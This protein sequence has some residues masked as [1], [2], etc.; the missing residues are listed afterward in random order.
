M[1]LVIRFLPGVSARITDTEFTVERCPPS[2][3][4]E[5]ERSIPITGDA[6]NLLPGVRVRLASRQHPGY[7][8]LDFE[9]PRQA[10]I[11]RQVS[12]DVL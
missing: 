1:G 8:A 6:A 5:G 9:A 7:L 2:L 10:L 4:R 11:V 3:A 12:G